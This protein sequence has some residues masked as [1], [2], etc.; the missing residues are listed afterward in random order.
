M[1]YLFKPPSLQDLEPA[2]AFNSNRKRA[3]QA[4]GDSTY[5]KAA[6]EICIVK[7]CGTAGHA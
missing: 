1:I 4:C 3:Q 5:F 7:L 2:D 6:T